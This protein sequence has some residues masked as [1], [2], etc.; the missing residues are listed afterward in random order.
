MAARREGR[1]RTARERGD[2]E[3]AVR[4]VRDDNDRFTSALRS[5]AEGVRR[6]AGRES[7]VDLGL[8]EA[9]TLGECGSGLTRAAERAR[10]DGVRLDPLAAQPGAEGLRVLAAGGREG[11]Q[12]IGFPRR[13]L[14]MA[15]DHELHRGQD[16]RVVT[17][18]GGPVGAVAAF[19]LTVGLAFDGGGF[20]LVSV[21]RAL[22]G[23]AAAALLLVVLVGGSRPGPLSSVLLGALGLLTAW[24]AASWLWSDSPPVALDE[25]QRTAAYLAAALL[26]VFAGRRVPA[27]WLAGGIAAGATVAV[28]WNLFLRLAPDWAGREP[29][30][31]DIGQ[32]ADPVGYANSI[33]LLAALAL[34]LALGLG[35]FAV[36]VA[37][38]L[39]AEI[40]LEQS[41][42]TD[43]ALA[44]GLVAY[45]LITARPLRTV[46]LLVLPL[47]GALV[48]SR[49]D[50]VQSPPPGDLLAASH[51]GHRLLLLLVL[52]TLAELA[53][54][55]ARAFPARD[56]PVPAR[57]ARLLAIAAGVVTVVAA[58]FA[59][60]GHERRHYWS[61]AWHEFTANVVLGSGAGTF[62]DWWLRLR[63]VP[64]STREA[65]SLYLQTLAELGP[66]GLALVLLAFG[67][68]LAAAWRVRRE[69]LGPALFAALL[70]YVLA[71]AVDFHWQLAA[72]T[73]PAIVLAAAA[74]VHADP[75]TLTVRG[76]YVVPALVALTCAG[77]LAL[78]GSSALQ[79]G[80]P[81]RALRFAPYSSAA[82]RELAE[83]RRANGDDAGAIRAY[84]RAVQ[85]DPNDW[86]AWSE[87]AAVSNG[88]PRRLALAEAARLNPFGVGA[89]R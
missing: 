4:L 22:V 12:L 40:A 38:P 10:D 37:V 20:D 13:C 81:Q 82:W 61:V 19:A 66:V 32:L 24:T 72:V 43:A 39:A 53:L 86:R 75:A 25:A 48:V 1:H 62:V 84:R 59:L 80:N 2:C 35:G 18:L 76:W 54:V 5:L 23:L 29:L 63:T 60:A 77:V 64:Q 41:T 7:V 3:A 71:A 50:S 31:S 68:G 44:L 8:C 70:T 88:E 42:G 17:R 69:R 6:G 79:A 28:G 55:V 83:Q 26:V 9:D 45:V 33:A 30:R 85:L 36:V 51:T 16:N 78:A 74:T 58:P 14:C 87:L 11:A 67:A 46:V 49:A 56:R 27:E 34:V 52:L 89:P 73:A 15:D 21:D 47:A 57:A 65:H